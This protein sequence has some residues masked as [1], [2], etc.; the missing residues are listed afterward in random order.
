MTGSSPGLR[1]GTLPAAGVRSPRPGTRGG[2]S[3]QR[4][5]RVLHGG[6]RTAGR[7]R[8]PPTAG[9]RKGG[10]GSSRLRSVLLLRPALAR[11]LPPRRA[12]DDTTHPSARVVGA[13]PGGRPTL[14]ARS[15]AAAAGGAAARRGQTA[16]TA[17]AARD[18]T[19]VFRAAGPRPRAGRGRLN[20][21]RGLR[22]RR[23]RPPLSRPGEVDV[24]CRRGLRGE[25][26]RAC[27]EAVPEGGR[28]G[29]AR[30]C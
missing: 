13:C 17:R 6:R 26:R 23:R 18:T 2:R 30:G 16:G 20:D 27:A 25:Y 28:G 3:G 12:V 10:Q 24:N 1:P 14:P 11:Q 19:R 15:T 21:R 8:R 29:R 7:E 5:P 22:P 9:A 4:G